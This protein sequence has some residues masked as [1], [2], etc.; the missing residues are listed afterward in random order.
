[1]ARSAFADAVVTLLRDAGRRAG[2]RAGRATLV[3]ERYDWS[4]VAGE[5]DAA[6][7]QCATR[8]PYV[9]NA[10]GPGAR[11]AAGVR[12]SRQDADDRMSA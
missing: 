2:A 10:Q 1:M 11:R 6:L 5:L 12:P 3:V 7:T 8:S 4:A 9:V